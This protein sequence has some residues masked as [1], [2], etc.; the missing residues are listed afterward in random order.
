L[1]AC[2]MCDMANNPDER[3]KRR[4]CVSPTDWVVFEVK[5]I[6]LD[7]DQ[8]CPL[9]FDKY[10][11]RGTGVYKSYRCPIGMIKGSEMNTMMILQYFNIYRLSEYQTWPN[12]KTRYYQP[13]PLTM[14]FDYLTWA[15]RPEEEG[16]NVK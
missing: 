5:C 10:W 13:K 1:N 3:K 12:S 8:Q 9:C 6:C 4:G 11:N 15:T 7:V 14:A 2:R 16:N